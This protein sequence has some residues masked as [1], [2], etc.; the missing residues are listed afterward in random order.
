MFNEID[1]DFD[2]VAI[3]TF[4]VGLPTEH[5]LKK[6]LTSKLVT[7]VHQL[8]DRIGKYKSVKEDQQ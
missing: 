7:N 2:D 1:S 4:M 3:S 5:D 6:S 8:I